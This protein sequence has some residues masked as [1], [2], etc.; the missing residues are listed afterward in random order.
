MVSCSGSDTRDVGLS[1]SDR[2]GQLVQSTVR[3]NK[4]MLEISQDLIDRDLIYITSLTQK[5]RL[6]IANKVILKVFYVG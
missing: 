5:T 4:S 2:P 3:V 6:Y 1:K